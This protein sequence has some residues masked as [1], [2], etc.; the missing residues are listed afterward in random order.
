MPGRRLPMPPAW[1][2]AL[3]GGRKAIDARAAVDR[4]A[5]DG[6]EDAQRNLEDR[7]EL[8]MGVRGAGGIELELIR[9]AE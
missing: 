5:S 9:H 2:E 4:V 6:R 8:T 3:R 1:Q 7:R